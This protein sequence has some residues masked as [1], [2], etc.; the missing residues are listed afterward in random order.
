MKNPKA[1]TKRQKI[2]MEYVGLNFRNWLVS[3]A[4][5]D[6]LTIVHRE[7]GTVKAIPK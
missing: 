3:K 5:G 2:A 7:T 6:E 1:P 4:A